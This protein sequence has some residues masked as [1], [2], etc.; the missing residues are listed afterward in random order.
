MNQFLADS[1]SPLYRYITKKKYRT[2]VNMLTKYG[3][4]K[5]FESKNI[6]FSG[7]NFN[8]IDVPSFLDHY[9]SIIAEEIYKFKSIT[10]SPLIYDCGANIGISVLYFKMLYPK[11]RILAFEADPTIAKVLSE[12]IANNKLDNIQ[13]IDKALWKDNEGIEFSQEGADGGSMFNVG[14][15]IKI[16]S[17]RL[18]ELLE[19]ESRIDF[20]KMDIEGAEV[21]VIKDCSDLLHKC[22]NIFVEY[23]SYNG[24]QQELDELL[25]IFTK[26]GFRYFIQT[27]NYRNLPYI[28]TKGNSG[29][30][31]QLNIY[32]YKV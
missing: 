24:M 20:L 22:D 30:D 3:G 17:I 8:V 26:N 27:V 9:K 15:K 25:R 28:N 4:A 5:R 23:H 6:N 7:Y 21:E 10:D 32:G 31:L 14:K 12:N 11:S 19:A 29:M 16:P 18:R 2:Y 1:L 13:V